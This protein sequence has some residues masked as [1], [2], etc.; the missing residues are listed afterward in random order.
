MNKQELFKISSISPKDDFETIK[1]K[2]KWQTRGRT[3]TENRWIRLIDCDTEH[4]ENIIYNVPKL[5]PITKRVIL[6]I[7]HE[8]WKKE[9]LSLMDIKLK[10]EKWKD[11]GYSVDEIDKMLES[12]GYQYK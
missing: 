5:Y 2:L 11:E 12:V 1:S 4:L 6:S 8:R 10:I 3:G 7:L 9:K